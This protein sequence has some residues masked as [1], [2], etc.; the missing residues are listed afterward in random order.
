MRMVLDRNYS[1]ACVAAD[2]ET[3]LAG[4]DGSAQETVQ[5]GPSSDDRLTVVSRVFERV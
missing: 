2:P 5:A 4:R 3:R 1:S